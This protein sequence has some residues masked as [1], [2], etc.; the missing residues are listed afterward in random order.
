[1]VYIPHGIVGKNTMYAYDRHK[2]FDL[3]LVPG[4]YAVKI[5]QE[6]GINCCQKVGYAILDRLFNNTLNR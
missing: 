2:A 1:K 6:I 4:D 5:F 3:L